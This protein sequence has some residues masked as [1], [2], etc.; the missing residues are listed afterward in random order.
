MKKTLIFLRNFIARGHSKRLCA[1]FGEILTQKGL[2][3]SLL[4]RYTRWVIGN[5]VWLSMI[6]DKKSKRSSCRTRKGVGLSCG[7]WVLV[8]RP[9][10][11]RSI[12]PSIISNYY[13]ALLRIRG[14][15]IALHSVCLSVCLSVRPVRG[16]SFLIVY[17]TTVLR[18]N[19]QNRKTSVFDYRPASTLRTCG[20]FCFVYMCGPH[21]VRRSA[22]QAC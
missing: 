7:L 17:I 19:I 3:Q 5:T 18:A 15:H 20:I 10:Q 22:A 16:S 6:L 13:A 21:K 2:N 4:I 12:D 8:L 1:D 9:K 11:S 14:P